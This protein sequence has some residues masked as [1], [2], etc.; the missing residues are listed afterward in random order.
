MGAGALLTLGM[1]PRFSV[2]QELD[3]PGAF[4]ACVTSLAVTSLASAVLVC[5][6][7]VPPVAGH[8]TRTLSLA[9]LRPPRPS[10][11]PSCTAC[12]T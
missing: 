5:I 10:L 12:P 11:S 9:L 4:E 2:T 6:T 7:V 8:D 3:I 1:G